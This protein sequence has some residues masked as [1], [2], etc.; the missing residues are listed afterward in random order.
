VAQALKVVLWTPFNLQA[1][2][3]KGSFVIILPQVQE[4]IA[5]AASVCLAHKGIFKEIAKAKVLSFRTMPLGRVADMDWAMHIGPRE[6]ETYI[7]LVRE[8][9]GREMTDYNFV[10]VLTLRPERIYDEILAPLKQGR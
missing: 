6:K 1:V 8:K 9:H 2:S 4:M 3:R 10:S 7:E 5:G